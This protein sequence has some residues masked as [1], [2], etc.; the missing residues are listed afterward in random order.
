MGRLWTGEGMGFTQWLR[1]VENPESLGSLS[2]DFVELEPIIVREMLDV[3]QLPLSMGMRL[4]DIN[5]TL[6]P[7]AE[8]EQFT[9]DRKSYIHICGSG[10]CFTIDSTI[11]EANG[12]IY[13]VAT[14]SALI[15]TL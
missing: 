1:P 4:T 2:I 14:E 5:R 15:R 10:N 13:L 7:P 11:D 6:G 9:Q 3:I 12:L 8:I